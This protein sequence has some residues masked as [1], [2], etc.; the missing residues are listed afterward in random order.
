MADAEAARSLLA[1]G[2]Y[3]E[4]LAAIEAALNDDP[5]D[6]DLWNSKGV[7][8]RSM[9]RYGEASECFERSLEIEPRDKHS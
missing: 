2:R 4:A 8:L 3:G 1:E 6:P 9:G 5:S 7:A